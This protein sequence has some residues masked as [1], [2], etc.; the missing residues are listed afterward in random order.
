MKIESFFPIPVSFNKIPRDLNK[1][2]INF[3]HNERK[4]AVK[5]PGNLVSL[6]KYILDTHELKDLKSIL[7]NHINEYFKTVFEPEKNV[8]LYITNSWLNWNENGDFHHL[9][10]HP[11]SLISGVIYIETVSGDSINFFNPNDLLGNIKINTTGGTGK[12]TCEEWKCPVDKNYVMLF[13][14]TL[15]HRVDSRRCLCNNT[16]ISLAFNTWFKGIIGS[17]ETADALEHNLSK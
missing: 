6:N 10:R 13:P 17:R 2:E 16:R 9:H 12:W 1:N 11:N 15:K 8:E 3:I 5:N 14:S 4:R 7:T